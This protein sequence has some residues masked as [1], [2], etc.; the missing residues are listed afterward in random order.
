MRLGHYI[1]CLHD[2]GFWPISKI[3]ICSISEVLFAIDS[4]S[5]L[6]DI[7]AEPRTMGGTGC[8]MALLG[9]N[10]KMVLKETVDDVNHKVTGLCLS[11]VNHG[12]YTKK[13]GNCHGEL[14]CRFLAKTEHETG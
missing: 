9:V 7:S 5:K 13:D 14:E 11:C 4:F 10:W 1:K 12:R 8:S 3:Q 2:R 6:D